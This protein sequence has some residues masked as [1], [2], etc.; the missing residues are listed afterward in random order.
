M[1]YYD[2]QEPLIVRH[3]TNGDT[4]LANPYAKIVNLLTFLFSIEFGSPPLYAEVNRVCM[5]NNILDLHDLGPFICAFQVIIK[6]TEIQKGVGDK[7]ECGYAKYN[8]QINFSNE[9]Y[10]NMV[11]SFL[12]F[13]GARMEADW[14]DLWEKAVD[15]KEGQTPLIVN[16]PGFTRCT[17]SLG[18]SFDVMKGKSSK[19]D[20]SI[21]V[22]FVIM[23]QNFYCYNGFRLSN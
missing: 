12:L 2:Y 21:P 22:I 9:L 5:T 8:R 16:M 23:N 1:K 13:K 17:L 11:S 20:T 4:N 7:I 10:L 14:I 18:H 15:F 3:P 6:S 19:E